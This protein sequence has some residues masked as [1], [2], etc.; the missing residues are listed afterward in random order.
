MKGDTISV[1]L[2]TDEE[3]EAYLFLRDK[4]SMNVSHMLRQ[5]IVD[6]AKLLDFVK[7][8]EDGKCKIYVDKEKREV[9]LVQDKGG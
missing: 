9:G 5:V 8:I 1:R 7:D 4:A 3:K 6:K 2:V